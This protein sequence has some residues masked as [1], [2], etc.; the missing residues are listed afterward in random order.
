MLYNLKMPD[1]QVTYLAVNFDYTQNNIDKST[2]IP[3]VPPEEYSDDD[4][5]ESVTFSDFTELNGVLHINGMESI[6]GRLISIEQE[7]FNKHICYEQ[8]ISCMFSEV[9]IECLRM[10]KKQCF[11]GGSETL[12]SII[13]YIY[14]HYSLPLSNKDIADIYNLHPNYV[15]SLVK[16]YTGMSL[17]QYL[18][19][20]RIIHSLEYLNSSDMNIGEIALKCG[21]SDIYQFSKTFKK[22]MGISPAK[23][24]KVI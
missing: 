21:F 22:F 16:Q 5:I 17:H 4:R 6:A 10:K 19:K 7:F 18:L 14:E 13:G 20:I 15:N 23:Y 24:Y 8:I 3:P 2:P 12:K 1:K 9:L 11:T